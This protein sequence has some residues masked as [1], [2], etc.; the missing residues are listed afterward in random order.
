M[1][2]QFQIVVRVDCGLREI[3]KDNPCTPTMATMRVGLTCCFDTTNRQLRP[4][5]EHELAERNTA[6]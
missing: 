2:H 5:N 6:F 1:T 3:G 4:P